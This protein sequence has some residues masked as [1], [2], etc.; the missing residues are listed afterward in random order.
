[1][2]ILEAICWLVLGVVGVII[3][4]VVINIIAYLAAKQ[5]MKNNPPP[6]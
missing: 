1:M 2:G 4:E 3:F 6:F 5:D